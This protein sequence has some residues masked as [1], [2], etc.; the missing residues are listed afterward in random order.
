MTTTSNLFKSTPVTPNQFIAE[1]NGV[2]IYMKREDLLHPEVSGNKFRKLKYNIAEAASQKRQILLTFGG[3]FSNH[4]AATAAAGKFSG[5]ETVGVIRGEELANNLQ[6]TLQ[7]NATLRFA[8][9]CGMKLH[10]VSR[11]DY[12][13]KTSEAFIKDLRKKFG[14]FYR[15]PEGGTNELAVKGCEEILSPKDEGFDVIACAIGTGGTISGLIN[16]S[17]EHQQILGFPALKGDFLKA[18]VEGFSK[19]NNWKIIPDYHFGGYAKVNEDLIYFIN[20]FRKEFD[21]QLDPVYTGKMMYGIFELAK[22]KYF[23]KNTRIL[24]IHTGG[25]QGISGMNKVLKMR[26]LPPIL[27]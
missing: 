12:R 13:N 3:A 7:E 14:D 23:S 5:F 27:T 2:S 18:E 21:V 25:L 11:S 4:I 20:S 8:A 17:G 24:A 16:A 10:F 1:V 15:V 19:K 9:D 22:K 6:K 26:N